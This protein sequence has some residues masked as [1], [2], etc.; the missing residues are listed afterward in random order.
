MERLQEFHPLLKQWCSRPWR[1][2]H[3]SVSPAC[4]LFLQPSTRLVNRPT[5]LHF[6]P[7]RRG[8]HR[9]GPVNPPSLSSLISPRAHKS[10]HSGTSF[11]TA[12]FLSPTTK[13]ASPFTPISNPS[14]TPAP[15]PTAGPSRSPGVNPSTLNFNLTP[16]S[17]SSTQPLQLSGGSQAESWSAQTG[18]LQW[19]NLDVMSGTLNPGG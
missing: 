15:S 14:A 17:G 2:I 1:R 6:S 19:L 5:L 8:T 16:L 3:S 10:A 4:R 11:L 7:P 9:P 13:P 12:S 18:G